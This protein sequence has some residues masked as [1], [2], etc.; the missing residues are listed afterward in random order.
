LDVLIRKLEA[1]DR[2]DDFDCGDGALNDYLRR[3][4]LSNQGYMVGTTYVSVC[5][6]SRIIGY[7]TI[8]NTNIP[9][10]AIPDGLL[11]GLPK[12]QDMPAILLGRFAV[13]RHDQGKRIGELLLTH[14]FET[15]L[16]IAKLCAARYLLTDA[17][18]S[19]VPWYE[20]YGFTKILGS[21]NTKTTKMFLDF[22][23]VRAAIDRRRKDSL[24]S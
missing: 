23:V 7:Y 1:S 8:A 21:S 22:T 13:N 12:Y 24:D 17:Y 16:H 6:P 5:L 19:A 4:A 15:C 10:S 2:T 11:K 18:E 9:R 20:R 14:C 3:Y